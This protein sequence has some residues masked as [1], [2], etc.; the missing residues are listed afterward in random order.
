LNAPRVP[1]ENIKKK[2]AITYKH[3]YLEITDQ[4]HRRLDRSEL[5]SCAVVSDLCSSV[6]AI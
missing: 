6:N 5:G 2:L 4:S 3:Q 1:A